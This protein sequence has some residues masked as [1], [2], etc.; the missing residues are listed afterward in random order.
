MKTIGNYIYKTDYIGKGSFSKVYIGNK[1]DNENFKVAVK[2]I[3]KKEDI[4]YRKYIEKEIEIMYKLNHKNIIKLYDTIE[5]EKHIF[6][7]LELCDTDLHKFI[8]K[9]KLTETE[10]QYIIRQ[11]IEAIKYIMDNNIVHRDLK[12]HNILINKNMEIKEFNRKEVFDK[13]RD[14]SDWEK[15]NTLD[16]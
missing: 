7:I 6:L 12:P 10:I 3:Y 15:N 13:K 5:T 16:C 2:K 8:N 9:N 4:K 11:I 14:I 1:K